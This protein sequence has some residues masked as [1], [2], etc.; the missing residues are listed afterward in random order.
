MLTARLVDASLT[1]DRIRACGVPK[2]QGFVCRQVFN[3][4]HNVGFTQT[5]DH[6]AIA[7]NII[8][9][10]LIAFI[11]TRVLHLV[12]KLVVRRMSRPKGRLDTMPG[13]G[14]VA[15]MLRGETNLEARA[16]RARTLGAVTRSLLD[17]FVWATALVMIFDQ[18][19][20]ALGPLVAGA[21]I[22]G[23]ALGFGAQS[24]VR[25]FLS[26]VFILS[27]NQFG[28]GD[29]IDTGFA[30][31]VVKYITVRST[32]L[33]DDDGVI[34]Y[35]PN[36]KIDRVGNR[37]SA[38]ERVLLDVEIDRAA[39]TQAG[40]DAVGRT[41][42]AFGADEAWAIKCYGAPTVTDVVDEARNTLI[43]VTVRTNQ[44][45]EWAVTRELRRR[46][47]EALLAVGITM[48]DADADDPDEAAHDALHEDE[49]ERDPEP[50]DL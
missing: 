10:L 1:A 27:E 48:I 17:L 28:V 43:Q 6:F 5:V 12:V 50:G 33:R 44:L 8:L 47:G 24:L 3:L 30:T 36:G 29:V 49:L 39:D 35:I 38:W 19:G 15:V 22:I 9:L 23:V 32:V 31:G 4:T 21:G 26:G 13:V 42:D 2:E 16:Q 37:S 46:I 40:I 7:V 11:V 45:D 18:L 20:I 14:N 34:W 41:I 25:D